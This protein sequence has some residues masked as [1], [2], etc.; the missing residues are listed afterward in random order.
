MLCAV[1]RRWVLRSSR[2]ALLTQH[3]QRG[4][5]KQHAIRFS[6]GSVCG[7]GGGGVL[8]AFGESNFQTIRAENMFY[9]DKT[10][11]AADLL[12]FRRAVLLRP[13]RSGKTL[14][15]DTVDCLFDVRFE[16]QFDEL[17]GGLHVGENKPQQA[18]QFYVV[19]IPLTAVPTSN[20]DRYEDAFHDCVLD[21]VVAFLDGHHD[22][23]V[24]M[25][26]H[27][28]GEVYL[29]YRGN[30]FGALKRIRNIVGADKLMVLV[31]EYDRAPM[32]L[33]ASLAPKLDRHDIAAALEPVTD[34]LSGLLATLKSLGARYYVTGIFTVPGLALSIFNDNEDL[35]HEA[36]FAE[37]FGMSADDVRRGLHLVCD[38]DGEEAERAVEF[39][40]KAANG[41]NFFGCTETLFN[42]QL[43]HRFLND[44]D[45]KGYAEQL[46]TKVFDHN[47]VF[48]H[49]GL[50]I[51]AHD[52]QLTR[53]L[54]RACSTGAPFKDTI[55][56]SA[57]VLSASTY[58]FQLGVLTLQN[59][60]VEYDPDDSVDLV[61]PNFSV[62]RNYARAFLT[63]HV[64]QVGSAS[65][66][67][68]DPTV[69]S[70]QA[71]LETLMTHQHWGSDQTEADLQALLT[72]EF[73]VFSQGEAGAERGAEGRRIDLRVV[74]PGQH[75]VLMELKTMGGPIDGRQP[76]QVVRSEDLTTAAWGEK[77]TPGA[78]EKLAQ[79]S[80]EDFLSLPATYGGKSMTISGVHASAETQLARYIASENIRQAETT[81]LPVLAFAVTQVANRCHVT[82]VDE[83]C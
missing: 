28:S 60:G 44:Y 10:R 3:L 7:E 20:L 27:N 6:S 62:R 56:T 35:T 81:K 1:A 64:G 80:S 2:V 79:F 43:V 33:F 9:V 74:V 39:L 8:S 77:Y 36:S 70:L 59:T 54:L 22:I 73:I 12:N 18:N 75:V 48:S 83:G 53:M 46:P 23:L 45:S 63:H 49:H 38:V 57:D 78:L 14:F 19:K 71:L 21:G 5:C 40:R 42:P 82:L 13:P 52:Q 69:T 66:F 24:S 47:Q 15:V 65:A 25:G 4:C 32:K 30:S 58:L 11:Y 17:F 50:Q 34:P 16:D 29:Q 68:H 67:L 41:Y 55:A 31:D 72:A 26:F 76:S 51:A 61:V 37:A